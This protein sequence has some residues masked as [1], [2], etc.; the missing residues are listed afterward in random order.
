MTH[1]Q[2][3][4][5]IAKFNHSTTRYLGENALVLTDCA[6]LAYEPETTVTAKLTHGWGFDRVAC[7]SGAS[8]QAFL[9]GNERYLIIAFR[10]TEPTNLKDWFR[11]LDAHFAPGPAGRVH[12]GFLKAC[13]EVWD[14]ADGLRSLLLGYRDNEQ[15]LWLAGHSLGGALALLTAARLRHTE[16]LPI[17]GLYT[18]GQPR[19]GDSAFAR[20]LADGISDRYFRFVNNNDVVTRVPAW[21]YGYR[22]GGNRLYFDSAGRLLDSISPWQELAD[23]VSGVV[24]SIG[25][26]GLDAIR[27]HS[28][29]EYGRL[30][31]KNRQVTT[32]WS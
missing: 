7:F 14:G 26:L 28:Q 6:R 1:F 18:I 19:V 24:S 8:T 5:D 15:S 4:G 32:R 27:D 29:S 25:D 10:G 13:N 21:L 22:H 9:G 2:F 30:V 20:S 3:Q 31:E 12:H 16:R 17:Q 23:G 11:D